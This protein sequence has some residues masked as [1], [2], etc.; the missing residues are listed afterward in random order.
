MLQQLGQGR[1]A[2]LYGQFTQ[3]LAAEVGQVEQVVG[4]VIV[5]L[6]VERG[7]QGLEV[8]HAVLVSDHHLTVQ[9]CRV[10]PQRFQRLH[11]M[12]QLCAP[13]VAIAGKQAHIVPVDAGQHAVTIELDLVSPVTLG[14][15]I[16][17]G[18]QLRLEHL[19]QGASAGLALARGGRRLGWTAG[20][21]CTVA[22]YAVRQGFDDAVV[23]FAA[24]LAI[25]G[26][27]QHPLLF[28]ASQ[29]GTKQVPDTRQLF[30]LQAKAQLALGIGLAR[31]A[32]GLPEPP[33]PHDH[34]AR[35]VMAF[36]DVPFETGVVQRMVFY[37]HGQAADLGV[38]GRALGNRPA[39]KGAIQ[40]QA[41]V[42]VQVA[43]VVLLD[44]VLQPVSR[45]WVGTLAG[46]L[47]CGV[48]VTLAQVLLQGLGHGG[49][50][51]SS[52]SLHWEKAPAHGVQKKRG[53]ADRRTGPLPE[54]Q[55][56]PMAR[57]LRW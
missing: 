23:R 16:G 9:P 27:D 37:M 46:R 48:E 28:L 45:P 35:A 1:P 42:I 4:N 49:L 21:Q 39:F 25:V 2:V 56:S 17:Q 12:G 20:D 32:F 43:G 8:G 26:L 13:V 11:L 34:V 7:L 33:V 52:R 36:G 15:G 31:V 50:R 55:R 41:K 29:V 10:E 24:G 19:R 30:T 40:L 3:V 44:A 14:G 51:D 54:A 6:V 57:F 47:G 22:Q 18:C 38:E 5:V 53:V